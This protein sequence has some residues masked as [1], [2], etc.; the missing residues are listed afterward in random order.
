M[1]NQTRYA[2][3]GFD[4]QHDFERMASDVLNLLGYTSVEPMAPGGGPDGGLDIRFREGDVPGM[5]FVTL[6]K[7]IGNK[8]R[9]DL[10]KDANAEGVI[11]LFCNVD[12]SPAMKLTLARE[13]IVKGYRLEVFDVERLRSLLDSSLKDVRRRYLG[14]DDEVAARLRSEAT[15]LLRFPDATPAVSTPPALLERLLKSKIPCRMFDLLMRY[16]EGEIIDV[17]GI[18][19]AL[20]DH[21]TGYYR[22][23][24]EALRLEHELIARIGMMVNVQFTAGWMI[25]LK[26]LIMRFSGASKEDVIAGGNFLNY[27]ITWDEAE[28]VFVEISGDRALSTQIADLFIMHGRL[29]DSLASIDVSA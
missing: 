9:R 28:R 17:H 14:I 7:G 26:Y 22:F 6:D 4:N 24:Q 18:G 27:D 5:A 20:H 16:E 3:E 11:A 25:Y 21:L 12:V 19:H 8:F 1:L 10:A 29:A 2:L 13:A 23:R 15:K